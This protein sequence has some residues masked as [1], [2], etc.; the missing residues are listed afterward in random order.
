MN[1]NR[2]YGGRE[3][4]EG[5]CIRSRSAKYLKLSEVYDWVS[6]N[7]LQMQTGRIRQFPAGKLALSSTYD[8]N[9]LIR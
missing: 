2:V 9:S 8:R 7:H 5:Q 1:I 6:I 3:V 4:Y